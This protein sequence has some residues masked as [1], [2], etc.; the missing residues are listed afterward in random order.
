MSVWRVFPA[1][2]V[3]GDPTLAYGYV[4]RHRPERHCCKRGKHRR[5]IG[6]PY[7][8]ACA[9]AEACAQRLATKLNAVGEKD[10]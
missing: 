2:V 10:G 5:K 9:I 3:T 8:N 6:P 7:V 1:R 4:G